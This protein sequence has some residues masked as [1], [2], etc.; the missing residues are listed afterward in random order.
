MQYLNNINIVTKKGKDSM[1]FNL[2]IKNHLEYVD[3]DGVT[4]Y[5]VGDNIVCEAGGKRYIGKIAS[6]GYYRREE[7]PEPQPAIYIDTSKNETSYS[8]EVIMVED[9]TYLYNDT[10]EYRLEA[11]GELIDILHDK[12]DGMTGQEK[13]RVGKI[14]MWFWQLAEQK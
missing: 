13:D 11:M 2:E 6:I 1:G 4:I 14:L 7:D 8:G 3:R 10:A 5:S 12:W 9:I